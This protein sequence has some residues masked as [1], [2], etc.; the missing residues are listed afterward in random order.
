MRKSEERGHFD[1]E[2][3]D[4]YHTFS[5]GDYY[6]PKYVHFGSM[7]VLNEDRVRPGKGFAEHPHA[8][9]EIVTYVI[10]GA[11]E[12]KDSTG[13][14]SIIKAEDVQRMTAGLGITHSEFN[15]SS[16]ETVHF[17]QIWI[18]PQKKNLS[19]SYEQKNFKDKTNRLCLIVSH[20]GRDGSLKIHQNVSI[21]ASQLT[22]E[23]SYTFALK[24]L[25]WVQMIQGSLSCNGIP[26]SSG[27]GA[28]IEN[29]SKITLKGNKAEFI[30]LDLI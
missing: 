20:D 5:F 3:L 11:L 10:K 8:N 15:A 1:F 2:W 22:G 28:A 9:M 7:R 24:R 17:L 25:G 6:N 16:T 14:S 12:H 23:L 18:Y 21:Y 4:T 19:P 30:L 26:L 13:S 29:E 27:D